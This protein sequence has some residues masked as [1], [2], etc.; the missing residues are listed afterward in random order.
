MNTVIY[1][2]FGVPDYYHET[3]FSLLSYYRLH[4]ADENRV[5]IYTEN[6]TFFENR[7][8]ACVQ[9]IPVP[10]P[11]MK[12]WRGKG[13]Y[14]YRVKIKVLQ[15]AASRFYGNLLYVDTDTLFL[16]NIAPLFFLLDQGACIMDSCEGSLR[17]NKGGIARKMKRVLRKQHTFEHPG[18]PASA[19]LNENFEVW[20]SG[21]VGFNAQLSCDAL[22]YTELLM[23]TLYNIYPLYTMEQIALTYYFS[24]NQLT[25]SKEF[26]HHYWYFKEFRK[27]LR[28]FFEVNDG[29]SFHELLVLPSVP[30]PR[31]LSAGKKRYKQMT[32][33]Q[34]QWQKLR[35]GKKY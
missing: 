21:T 7:I 27:P 24:A 28:Q 4:S 8:P 32:F 20:N 5:V 31:E 35:Y 11:T 1:L 16:K 13:G 3:V 33:W 30:D 14:P 12:E 10:E 6:G 26:I 15:D 29:K 9:I 23:D 22:H 34:K 19:S 18:L 25:E 17:D 2:S